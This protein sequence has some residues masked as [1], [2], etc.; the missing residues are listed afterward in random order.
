M[1]LKK[2]NSTSLDRLGPELFGAG[3][4]IQY[5][6]ESLREPDWQIVEPQSTSTTIVSFHVCRVISSPS[7]GWLCSSTWANEE[8]R[9]DKEIA[10][11]KVGPIHDTVEGF[12]ESLGL[13]QYKEEE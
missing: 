1:P 10:E 7:D 6:G 2:T 12:L 4:V 8:R 11:G 5:L 13:E 9:I 3:G